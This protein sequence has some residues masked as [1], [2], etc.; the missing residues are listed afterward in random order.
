MHVNNSESHCSHR[1]AFTLIELLVVIAIIA[2]LAGLLLPAL[3]RAKGS[4]HLTKCASN[5][6]QIGLASAMYVGDFGSYPDY[7]EWR[8]Q[9]GV[10]ET[11][12]PEYWIDKLVPYFSGAWTSDIYHCP[13]NPFRD[14]WFR[15]W[16]RG[17]LTN[18][19]NTFENG[20]NYDMNAQGVAWHHW[21][22][23]AYLKLAPYLLDGR[24]ASMHAGVKE[25]Q[26][27]SPSQMIAYGDA[28][29][30][31]HNSNLG[32]AAFFGPQTLA[33]RRGQERAIMARRHRGL[34]NLVFADGH[35]EHFKTQVLFGKNQY[36][37]ADEPMR[38]RW[39]RDHE[40]HWE[41]LSQPRGEGPAP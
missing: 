30:G 5:L 13:G 38:R 31:D 18:P 19:E 6:R 1:K 2:I 22:G 28:V 40:P 14:T 41:E 12:M 37:P 23:L 21:L 25:S 35:I 27:V 11:G 10:V 29:P 24:P 8:V 15:P 4:A 32:H 9:P 34:W 7:R 26:V 16:V 36:D 39:N 17:I 20:L 33:S 3:S